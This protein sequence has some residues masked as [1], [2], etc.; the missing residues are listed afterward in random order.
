L[1]APPPS[2]IFSGVGSE[3]RESLDFT[4]TITLLARIARF[5]LVDLTE[6]AS[7][8]QELQAIVPNVA[9]PVLPLLDGERPYSMVKDHWKYDRV[10]PVH[11]YAGLE[12]L[13]ASIQ[14]AV[15]TPA[16]TKGAEPRQRRVQVYG[17]S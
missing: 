3:K 17:A 5:I 6:A 12:E 8:P 11:R 1:P 4:E 2:S 16:E 9:V 10:L 13:L 7:I 15:I 14:D